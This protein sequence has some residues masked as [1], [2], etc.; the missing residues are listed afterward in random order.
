[1]FHGTIYFTLYLEMLRGVTLLFLRLFLIHF[2]CVNI[3]KGKN[4]KQDVFRG[5][6]MKVRVRVADSRDFLHV[7]LTIVLLLQIKSKSKPE[8]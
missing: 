2:A 8:P 7:P 4:F 3:D 5:I 6:K 1:M